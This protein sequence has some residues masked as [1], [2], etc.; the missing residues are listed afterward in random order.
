VVVSRDIEVSSDQSSNSANVKAGTLDLGLKSRSRCLTLWMRRMYASSTQ[1]YYPHVDRQDI[2]DAPR[3]TTFKTKYCKL[4][5]C[6]AYPIVFTVL[7]NFGMT[8]CALRSLPLV[9]NWASL[10][11]RTDDHPRIHT[12]TRCSTPYGGH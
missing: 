12:E 8:A 11:D 6:S 5:C 4:S 10:V 7:V 3:K 1:V 2:L 9:P